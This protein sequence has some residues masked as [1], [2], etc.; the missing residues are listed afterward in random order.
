[1]DILTTWENYS[2]RI[3]SLDIANIKY[4][5]DFL[6]ISLPKTS[7]TWLSYNL[8]CHPE[9]FIPEEKEIV[10]FSSYWKLLDINWYVKH[11]QRG[12]GQKKG[13]V[14]TSY[15]ILPCRAIKLIKSLMPNL[16]LIFLMRD[17]VDRAWSDTKHNY[18]YN[19]VTFT[20]YKGDFDSIP[21][22]KFIENFTNEEALIRG[23]YIGA[24]KKWCSV[25]SKGQFYI[26]FFESIKNNPKELLLDIF[27]HLGVSKNVDWS[28]FKTSE[29][30]FEGIRKEIPPHLKDYLR[31]IW[32]ERTKELAQFLKE[33]FNISLPFE[34][35]NTLE[36]EAKPIT[37]GQ[38]KQ[39]EV[40]QKD[41]DERYLADK[42]AILDFRLWRQPHVVEN[43][44]KG[45]S[46]LLY[47]GKL[48][49]LSHSIGEVDLCHVEE[50]RIEEYQKSGQCVCGDTLDEVKHFVDQLAINSTI[51]SPKSHQ[52]NNEVQHLGEQKGKYY[53]KCLWKKIKSFELGRK[54]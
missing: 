18:K 38:G 48:Y 19:E 33:E 25:F 22:S 14:S 10:Y 53:F 17:P 5:P 47:Q 34:W 3:G 52:L 46:I 45:F 54:R 1:M 49:A 7:S 44:Y 4:L 31:S 23:D 27:D 13:E 9:I 43:D 21:D 15:A 41:F 2:Q 20:S 40:F 39:I 36:P 50:G 11:F 29:K 42:L 28:K 6:A 30:I 51:N 32:Q 12:V 37:G 35:R 24:L 26:G 16:K 8:N